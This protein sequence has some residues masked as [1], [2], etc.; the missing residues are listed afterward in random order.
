MLVFSGIKLATDDNHIR[1][2]FSTDN[3]SNYSPNGEHE[4]ARMGVNAAGNAVNSGQTSKFF[5][6]YDFSQGIGNSTGEGVSGHVIVF[7]PLKQSGTTDMHTRMLAHLTYDDTGG[8]PIISSTANKWTSTTA[9]NNIKFD[10]LYE[11]IR[12]SISIW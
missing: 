1:L 5:V 8:D 9:V 3:G 7:D 11:V 2:F 10:A 6:V 12:K 4:N